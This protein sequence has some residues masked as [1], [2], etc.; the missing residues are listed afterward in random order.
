MGRD[1]ADL[2]R[3]QQTMAADPAGP[4]FAP[5]RWQDLRIGWLGDFDGYLPTE[6][7]VIELCESALAVLS[8]AGAAVDATTPRFVMSDLWQCSNTLR[9]ARR[10]SLQDY[11]NDPATRPLLKPDI[12][13]EI[14]NSL[15]VTDTALAAAQAVRDDWRR[16]LDR[17]FGTYDLLA[18]PSCQVFPFPKE[19]HWPRE[20][21]GKPMDSYI[22]WMEVMTSATLSGV[23]VVNVPAGFDASGRPMGMQFLGRFGRD[24]KVLEFALAYERTTGYLGQRPQLVESRL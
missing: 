14:E 9:A 11:Y 1:T 15:E 12:V 22:R 4:A 10:T 17:M 19:V 18:L 20:I 23:P 6:P 7:G 24:R 3:L 8:A 5:P 21:D 2:V 13:W 16:E